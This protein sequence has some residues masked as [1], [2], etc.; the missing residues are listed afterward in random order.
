MNQFPIAVVVGSLRRDSINC[1]LASAAVMP[2]PPEFSFKQAEIGD[3]PPYNQDDDANPPGSAK[4]LKGEIMA[5]YV[6]SS[7][8]LNTTV[9]YPAC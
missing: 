4:R 8:R 3:L 1:K 6:F 5:T 7:S 2:A 9:Q